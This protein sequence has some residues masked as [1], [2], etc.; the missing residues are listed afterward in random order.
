MMNAAQSNAGLASMGPMLAKMG[1][2]EDT[3]IAHVAPGEVVVPRQLMESNPELRQ[4]VMNAFKEVGVDPAQFIVGGD[5][6]MKN[7]VTGIQEFGLWGKLKKAVKKL[8]PVLVP[9]ALNFVAPGLASSLGSAGFGAVS[10]GLTGVVQGRKPEDV[11]KSALTGGAIG[12]ITQ[13]GSNLARGTK[14][15]YFGPA[16]QP[17]AAPSGPAGADK[18]VP[19]TQGV[20]IPEANLE[21]LKANVPSPLPRAIDQQDYLLDQ[22]QS[23]RL[24]VPY[25]TF[26]KALMPPSSPGLPWATIAPESALAT[27]VDPALKKMVEGIGSVGGQY[28]SKFAEP[29]MPGTFDPLKAAGYASIAGSM[30]VEEPKQEDYDSEAAYQEAMAEYERQV[31]AVGYK[32]APLYF[33]DGGIANMMNGGFTQGLGTGTSDSI[34]AYLSDGEFVMTAK[35]VEG[36]GNGDPKQRAAKMYAMM[37]KFERMA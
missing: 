24:A 8:A 34:P 11:L 32:P 10:G 18:L 26:G 3:Q 28:G 21:A 23:A 17:A 1:R 25:K 14:G 13:L 12:G 4:E 2:F 27:S 30:F 7:P 29:F 9:L 37:D 33:A 16:Q 31:Q 36:A 6:V 19:T 22:F 15:G 35:A 20:K 5:V